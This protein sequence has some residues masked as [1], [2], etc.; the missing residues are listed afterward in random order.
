MTKAEFI[1]IVKM[2]ID[3]LEGGYYHPDM[4]NDGRINDL[5]KQLRVLKK[6]KKET[7]DELTLLMKEREVESVNIGNVGQIMYTKNTVKK[8]INK[9]YLNEILTEYYKTN[10]VLAKEVCDFILENRESQIKENIRLKK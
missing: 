3:N 7:A 6:S 1:K 8:G 10:P 4:L 2:I 9:K 5:Q